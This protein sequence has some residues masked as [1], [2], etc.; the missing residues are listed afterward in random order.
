MLHL[1]LLH[2]LSTLS[3]THL[4]SFPKYKDKHK[5]THNQKYKYKF[6]LP[7]SSLTSP[8]QKNRTSRPGWLLRLSESLALNWR[9]P[10]MFRANQGPMLPGKTS[11]NP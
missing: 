2:Y 6:P 9:Y 7:I 5:Y 8:P 3:L 11:L 10:A 4:P 1:P